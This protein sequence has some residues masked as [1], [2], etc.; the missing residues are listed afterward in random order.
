M[1]VISLV[2]AFSLLAISLKFAITLSMSVQNSV[3][4]FPHSRKHLPKS[5]VWSLPW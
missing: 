3:P 4:N 2:L 5:K 1:K